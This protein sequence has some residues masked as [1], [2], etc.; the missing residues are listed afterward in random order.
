[1]EEKD[2]LSD[3]SKILM[4]YDMEP[5]SVSAYKMIYRVETVAGAFAL[6]EIKYP[7]NEF[8]YIYG[9]MEHLATHGF[10]SINRIIPAKNYY[11]Y[12]EY[13]GKRYALSRWIKGREADYSRKGDLK[14]AAKTLALLHKSSAGFAPPPW[15]GRI[16]WGTWPESMKEKMDQLFDFKKRVSL[17]N[18]KTLFDHIFLS[19]VDYYGAECKKA[20]DLCAKSE[21]CKINEKEAL[22]QFF[23]HHDFAHHNVIID[24][25]G[26]GNVID[27][28]YC[29]SDIR[30]HDLG[31]L[32]L[33]VLKRSGWDEKQ[34]ALAFKYY[35]KVRSVSSKEADVVQVLLRFPQDFWQ[36]AFAYYVEQNQP[37]ERLLRKIK[38]WVLDKPQRE[39]GLSKLAKLI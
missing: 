1:M 31:S 4:Q 19:Y 33:R 12:A 5:L 3:F 16:K 13:G 30:C 37:R 14:I 22:K 15:E 7:E 2:Y 23:C 27:F 32:M 39:K 10:P 35:H 20:L 17:K 8:C 21:Y 34:A 25:K 26:R 6:K 38:S 11:P 29:I 18:R 36:V 24:R 28:D 9:A